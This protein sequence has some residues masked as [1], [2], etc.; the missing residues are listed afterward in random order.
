MK[1][2]T[3]SIECSA[4]KV[5]PKG[6][7]HEPLLILERAH[8]ANQNHINEMTKIRSFLF[9]LACFVFAAIF[10][11]FVSIRCGRTYYAAS[12][13]ESK[14][15]SLHEGMSVG[16]LERFI[17]PPLEKVRQTNGSVLWTYSGR[18]DDTCSFWRRW[19]FIEND[20]ITGVVSDYWE[21]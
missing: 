4:A 20:K 1:C 14:F 2:S 11:H 18:A 17:G 19:V 6:C 9:V 10:L 13:D 16:E 8:H 21:E 3:A 5:Q 15:N 12:F 7:G